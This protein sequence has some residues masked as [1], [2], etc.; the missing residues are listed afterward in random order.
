MPVREAPEDQPALR[1]SQMK[2]THT[3]KLAAAVLATCALVGP[4][5]ASAALPRP[6]HAL[7]T[8]FH[9][10]GKIR[11]GIAKPDAFGVWGATSLCSVGTGRR[12][13]CD[14][15]SPAATDFPEEGGVLELKGGEV[16]GMLMRAGTDAVHGSLTVTRLKQW[17]TKEGV[18]LGSSLSS[19]KHVLGGKLVVTK[20][21][22]TTAIL[23]GTTTPTSKKVEEIK[24]Y[25][26]GCEVT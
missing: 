21:H 19:A 9:S 5:L 16:C 17:K 1:G 4:S 12:V 11:L 22:V 20:H 2:S 6:N 18:G 23:G 13:T 15:L 3:W 26:Q 14:W 25:K 8:P 10:I 7:V 24:I